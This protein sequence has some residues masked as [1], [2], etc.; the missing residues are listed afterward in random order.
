MPNADGAEVINTDI[1]VQAKASAI[2]RIIQRFDFGQGPDVLVLSE[3]ESQQA[4]DAIKAALPDAGAAYPYAI[5]ID[6]DPTRLDPKPDRRG[7][8]VSKLALVPGVNGQPVRVTQIKAT[9]L[10]PIF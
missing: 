7:M 9:E 3:V 2:T 1:W 4:L 5:L 8:K 10:K 6:A